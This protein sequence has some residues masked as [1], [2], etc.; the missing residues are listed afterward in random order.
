MRTLDGDGINTIK[1]EKENSIKSLKVTPFERR[2][3]EAK[4]RVKELGPD[5]PDIIIKQDSNDRGRQYTRCFSRSWFSKKAWLTTCSYAIF[6]F[7][8]LLFKT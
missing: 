4:V 8:C 3:M 6:C 2:T 1:M 7:P 5:Q